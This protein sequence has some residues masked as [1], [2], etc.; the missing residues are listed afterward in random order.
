M[1]IIARL[2]FGFVFFNSWKILHI[3]ITHSDH[4]YPSLYLSALSCSSHSNSCLF[5]VVVVANNPEPN[6][7]DHIHVDEKNSLGCEQPTISN[8]PKGE[9]IFFFNL[10]ITVNC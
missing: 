7:A 10:S 2:V 5:V 9:Y 4:I 3:Y 1:A 8:G 6:Y